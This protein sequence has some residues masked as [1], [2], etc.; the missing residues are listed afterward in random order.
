[1][2]GISSPSLS[3][4]DGIDSSNNSN[5]PVML[6]IG[7]LSGQKGDIREDIREGSK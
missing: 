4:I 6:I 2:V 1:M 3:R 7:V 5:S